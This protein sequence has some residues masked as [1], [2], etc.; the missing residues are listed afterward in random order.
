MGAVSQVVV[1]RL[2]FNLPIGQHIMVLYGL[3]SHDGFLIFLLPG[4]DRRHVPYLLLTICFAILPGG[5]A[6]ARHVRSRRRPAT[7]ATCALCGYDLRATPER[8]PERGMI[9]VR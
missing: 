6:V 5:R 3:D 7:T 2:R 9:P 4:G 1:T 8:C